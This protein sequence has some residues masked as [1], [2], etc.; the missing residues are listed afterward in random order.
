MFAHM[1]QVHF[2]NSVLITPVENNHTAAVADLKKILSWLLGVVIQSFLFSM[3]I[4]HMKARGGTRGA[5]N[6]KRT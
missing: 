4:A 6:F 3:Y 5:N 2:C 1:S